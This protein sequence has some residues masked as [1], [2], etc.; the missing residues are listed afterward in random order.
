MDR[1][2]HWIAKVILTNW[3][4]LIRK[5]RVVMTANLMASIQMRNH[6]SHQ[7]MMENCVVLKA[8]TTKEKQRS[9][10]KARIRWSKI[11]STRWVEIRQTDTSWALLWLARV[12]KCSLAVSIKM[13]VSAMGQKMPFREPMLL[14]VS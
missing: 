1:K 8:S 3:H 5:V 11:K 14:E 12:G 7:R 13:K 4:I 2:H 9:Q 10:C 6:E